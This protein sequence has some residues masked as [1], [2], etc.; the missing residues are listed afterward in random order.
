MIVEREPVLHDGRAVGVHVE[1]RVEHFVA[2]DDAA[3]AENPSCFLQ[4]TDGFLDVLQKPADESAVELVVFER[5]VKRLS[6]S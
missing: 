3:R 6:E 1:A 5:K 2:V 4:N